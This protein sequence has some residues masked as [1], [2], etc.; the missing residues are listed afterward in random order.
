V[1]WAHEGSIWT[2]PPGRE[3]Q[4]TKAVGDELEA[5]KANGLNKGEATTRQAFNISSDGERGWGNHQNV[6]MKS[7][8]QILLPDAPIVG[9][10]AP[11]RYRVVKITHSSSKVILLTTKHIV[12]YPDSG[13]SSEEIALLPAVW[14]RRWTCVT[15]GEQRAWEVHVVKGEMDLVPCA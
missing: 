1:G 5:P 15:R 7:T 10:F 12:I 14:Y 9:V 11:V 4:A 2:I 13:P 6:Q 3:A 8:L